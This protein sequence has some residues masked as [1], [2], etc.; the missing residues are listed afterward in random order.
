MSDAASVK[1]QAGFHGF[2]MRPVETGG[3]TYYVLW[4]G[5]DVVARGSIETGLI[6]MAAAPGII[7]P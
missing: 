3:P 7:K 1:E 5:D 4:R 2:D 6:K